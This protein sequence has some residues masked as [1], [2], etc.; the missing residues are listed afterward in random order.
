MNLIATLSINDTGQ[1]DTEYAGAEC[2]YAVTF[3]YCY[4]ECRS[5]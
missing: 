1:N 5:A 4:A 2:L 3:S